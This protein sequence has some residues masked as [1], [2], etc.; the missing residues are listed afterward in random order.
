MILSSLKKCFKKL[1]LQHV[2]LLLRGGKPFLECGIVGGS[3]DMEG[4]IL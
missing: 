1:S 3:E 4:M 2:V